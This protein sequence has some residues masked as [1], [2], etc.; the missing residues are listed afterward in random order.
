MVER[1][2]ARSSSS[3]ESRSTPEIP[4]GSDADPNKHADSAQ[5]G[6]FSFGDGG[7]N[8]VQVETLDSEGSPCSV[9]FPGDALRIKIVCEAKASI[10]KLSIAI[11]LRN[12]EGVKIY[13]WGT[14]NQDISILA[15][16][17]EQSVFWNRRINDGE[18]FQVFFECLCNLG[19][20]LYE[21]QAAV[22]MEET[23]DY[24]SQRILHWVDEAAFFQV[25]MKNDEYF[26]G[27]VTDLRMKAIW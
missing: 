26:F 16:H 10:D 13:S 22:S 6:R 5:L 12:K 7:V 11:R 15:S 18:Q 17:S 25:L 24:M 9:Y 1:A 2:H 27:G 14:L 8:I 20:N 3:H 23:P 21:V 19:V 4:N